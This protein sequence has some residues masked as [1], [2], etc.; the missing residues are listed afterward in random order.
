MTNYRIVKKGNAYRIQYRFLYL[1]WRFYEESVW[2]ESDT[3]STDRAYYKP[4]EV[5]SDIKAKK[6]FLQLTMEAKVKKQ[7]EKWQVIDYKDIKYDGDYKS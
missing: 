2:E 7:K 5:L 4:Y 3:S 1:F 6:K